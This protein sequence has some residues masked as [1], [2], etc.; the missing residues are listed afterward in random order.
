MN[1]RSFTYRNIFNT[2]ILCL[3]MTACS[4]KEE[5]SVPDSIAFGV[6][7]VTEGR[8]AT[9]IGGDD[10]DAFRAQPFVVFGDWKNAADGAVLEEVFD[11]VSVVYDG[12]TPAP[13]GWNYTP[14]QR[15]KTDGWYD[16][17]AYWP[18]SNPIE[19]TS[20]AQTL[21][22][23]YNMQI[24]NEDLMVA[25]KGCPT[26]SGEV[27]LEFRHALAAVSVKFI[28]ENQNDTY[29]L[30]NYY[31][32]NLYYTGTLAYSHT[33]NTD[34]TGAWRYAARGTDNVRL[35][36]W[37]HEAGVQVKASADDFPEEFNLFLPQSLQVGEEAMKPSI[38]FTFD[39]KNGNTTIETPTITV[40][41]PDKDKA[42][43]EMVWQAGK[44]Y[45]YVITIK[46][47]AFDI[48]VRTT[49]WDE[50]NVSAGDIEF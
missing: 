42:G 47:E 37:T 40:A 22:L 39:V 44:K 14:I 35:R 27:N 17:R 16:F 49:Q 36:E 8:A 46:P 12:K 23:E 29:H 48:T 15:W 3:V 30:K 18:A 9:L 19:N 34:L 45:T 26:R 6:N 32:K 20:N 7:T 25:Y 24:Q 33:D 31:F 41:L 4:D 5:V 2:W 50:V 43:N 11:K 21:A 1:L 10:E 13:S 38:T 28:S